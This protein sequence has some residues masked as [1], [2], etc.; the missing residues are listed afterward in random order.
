MIE[1]NLKTEFKACVWTHPSYQITIKEIAENF[2]QYYRAAI[3][4]KAIVL[5]LADHRS[6]LSR[7]SSR[8]SWQASRNKVNCTQ[9]TIPSL[10]IFF[11]VRESTQHSNETPGQSPSVDSGLFLWAQFSWAGCKGTP[12]FTSPDASSHQLQVA[13]KGFAMWDHL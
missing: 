11:K 6:D 5:Q 8:V 4:R 1:Y 13:R 9:S 12:G 7:Q 3:Q 10:N 2:L